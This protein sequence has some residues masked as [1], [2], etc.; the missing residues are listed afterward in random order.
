[1]EDDKTRQDKMIYLT[2]L[3][4]TRYVAQIYIAAKHNT[5]QE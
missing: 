4:F 1:M 3:N 2:Q 5:A